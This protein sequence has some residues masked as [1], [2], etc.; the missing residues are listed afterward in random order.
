MEIS[1]IMTRKTNFPAGL[2]LIGVLY[3]PLAVI[4]S[5][6]LGSISG[7][8]QVTRAAYRNWQIQLTN[9]LQQKKLYPKLSNV[10]FGKQYIR[11]L[12]PI[13]KTN[14]GPR[15]EISKYAHKKA[16]RD[17]FELGNLREPAILKYIAHDTF[18]R[19]GYLIL[20]WWMLI[21]IGPI[22]F[23]DEMKDLWKE[24]FL[25]KAKLNPARRNF[26]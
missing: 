9:I 2:I 24:N 6:L 26:I 17:N 20:L 4:F 12:Y 13:D 1:T 18:I 25:K 7:I 10:R 11:E 23:F 8:V 5:L 19:M 22:R 15:E 21:F 14:L 16:L 3:F